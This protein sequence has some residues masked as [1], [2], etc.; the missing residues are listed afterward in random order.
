MPPTQNAV[1]RL[2]Q[3]HRERAGY[4]RAKLGSTLDISEG[5]I[6]GWELGRVERPP[7]HEV[8]RIVA[9]LKVPFEDLVEAVVA[10]SGGIPMLEEHVVERRQRKRGRKKRHGVPPMLEA[11]FRLYG[12][13][14]DDEAAEELGTTAERVRTWRRGTA[15]IDLRDYISLATMINLALAHALK[16][17]NEP[18]EEL[19]AAA[20][21]L[22]VDSAA[23]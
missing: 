5:T 17:G 11:A 21:V 20:E 7:F 22:G 18:G 14:D 9:F 2:L 1:A 15:P 12:W 4:S 19:L 23:N 6:E 3:G 16:S 8:T 13:Q 10:D